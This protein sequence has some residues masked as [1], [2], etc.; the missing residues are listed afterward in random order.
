MADATVV[1]DNVTLVGENIQSKV[2]ATLLGTKAVA[3]DTVKGSKPIESVLEQVRNL[4]EATVDKV[5]EVWEILKAQLDFEKDEARKLREQGRGPAVGGAG[6]ATDAD[7]PPAVKQEANSVLDFIKDNPL[8]S[9]AGLILAFKTMGKTLVKGGFWALIASMLG[10]Q[11]VKALD[12]E[13]DSISAEALGTYIPAG[14]LGAY[15]FGGKGAGGVGKLKGG[16]AGALIVMAGTGIASVSSWMLGSKEFGEISTFDWGAASM[17]G[18]AAT[19][20]LG[21]VLT[22]F[23]LGGAGTIAAGLLSLPLILSVGIGTAAAVGGVW[24][25]G[26]VQEYEQK[27]ND[28]LEVFNKQTQ[29][30]WEKAITTQKSGIADKWGLGEVA[31]ALG[32]KQTQLEQTRAGTE[33]ALDLVMKAEDKTK[34]LEPEQQAT[35]IKTADK[36]INISPE[37]LKAI[38]KD[39]ESSHDY[40]ETL[41]NLMLMAQ[42][43]AFGPDES[44]RILSRM[45]TH[46][47][48]VQT[49]SSVAAKELKA[50]D[51]SVPGHLTDITMGRGTWGGDLLEKRERDKAALKP[52][53]DKQDQLRKELVELKKI[54]EEDPSRKNVTAVQRKENEL[55]SIAGRIERAEK[56]QAKHGVKG[57]DWALIENVLSETTLTK[58]SEANMKVIAKIIRGQGAVLE[59]NKDMEPAFYQTSNIRN[60]SNVKKSSYVGVNTSDQNLKI[61]NNDFLY[62]SIS[63]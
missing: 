21:T 49:Q 57:L 63:S 62:Q 30:D 58:L 50:A 6:G 14:V 7:L 34:S 43:G 10:D 28:E 54:A 9:S 22:S 36:F 18:V 44:K 16:L 24:M 42:H 8:L 45:L 52:M 12:L 17:A 48:T 51:E 23:G 55:G 15:M 19:W 46:F 13:K 38:L 39:R 26:K 47:Q 37:S 1:A 2:G 5:T 35:L 20:G 11:I 25:Y 33:G 59:N 41:N 29:E 60:T 61:R 40:M 56:S 4:Q 32:F 3:E 53:T 31:G 27:M